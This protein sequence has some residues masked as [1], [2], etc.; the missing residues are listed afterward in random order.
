MRTLR[1]SVAGVVLVLAVTLQMSALPH[2]AIAGVTCDLVLL[3]V[4][5]FALARGPEFGAMTGFAG[6]LLLDVVPPAD[7]TAG[8]WV[9]ALAL[10]G[11][12]GGLLRREGATPVGPGQL[13]L[14]VVLC[15]AL[16]HLVFAG[17]GALLRDSSG[18]T[19]EVVAR[20][21]VAIGYDVLA[22]VLVVPLVMWGIGRFD[23]EQDRRR[24]SGG[25]AL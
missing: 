20:I 1:A 10:A 11:Y 22:A 9:L 21:G 6:G 25:V 4:V 7:H 3:V 12:L 19:G 14:S 17:T 15:T 13:G 23:S 16:A 2:I 8:R 5:G 24:L 18:D